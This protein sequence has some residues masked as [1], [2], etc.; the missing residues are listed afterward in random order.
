MNSRVG[1]A[2]QP[3]S[4]S[5]PAG[6]SLIPNTNRSKI[7]RFSTLQPSLGSVINNR[8]ELQQTKRQQFEA[9][10]CS[11]RTMYCALSGYRELLQTDRQ[12]AAAAHARGQQPNTKS[13][14]T[15]LPCYSLVNNAN[16][17]V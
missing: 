1:G 16:G 13:V 5:R 6:E 17:T 8:W 15:D 3:V 2:Q 10:R 11:V 14:V 12:T 4:A 7:P 9:F